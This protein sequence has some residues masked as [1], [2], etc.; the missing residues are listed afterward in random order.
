[1]IRL[2]FDIRGLGPLSLQIKTRTTMNGD[3]KVVWN[4]ED[5]TEGYFFT[6]DRYTFEED[7]S[8]Q[9]II[10]GSMTITKGKTNYIALDDI[11]FSKKCVPQI[12]P[13]P[14]V[15][16]QI[17][18]P[19]PEKRCSYNEFACTNKSQ[20]IPKEQKCDFK[21]DCADG[22]DETQC[23]K[24]DFHEDMCGLVNTAT[25]SVYQWKRVNA[26]VFSISK[27]ST[28][29]VSDSL[30][31][32][33]GYFA[34]LTGKQYYQYNTDAV[35]RTPALGATS[36][37][38]RLEFY[39][40]Y[41]IK[42]G[43]HL[44]VYVK[45]PGWY[46]STL[47]FERKD[48]D[49]TGKE[50][51]FESV[52]IGNY[53]AG[54]MIEFHGNAINPK[55][56][57]QVQDI[58]IDNINYVNCDPSQVYSDSL[59]CTFDNN[60]C[61]WH[62]DNDITAVTWTR[63]KKSPR[64]Y[65]PQSDHTGRKGFFMYISASWMYRKGQKA[66]LVSLKQNATDKRCFNFW[67]H[68]YGEDVGTLNLIVR[69]DTG[70]TT[71]WS[72]TNSQ[73]NA[74]KQ[75]MRT[76]RSE[77]P[78]QIV[79][80]GIV[81]SYANPVI[82][83]DDIEV[84]EEECPHPVACDFEA[85]F[86]E[87]N[88][89][90]FILQ[91]GRFNVPS[92]DHTTDTETGRYAALTEETGTLTSPDYNY[93]SN[94]YCLN[95]WYFLEGDRSTGLRVQRVE[96][97]KPDNATVLWADYA[98]P[99]IKGQWI[100]S[101]VSVT[102]LSSGDYNIVIF[103]QKNNLSNAVAVDDIAI[104][105]GACP[106][107]GSCNFERDF[108]TW[109]NLPKP[110]STG[111]QWLRNSGSI[112]NTNTGPK[113]D[114]TTGTTEGWYIY[115]D[116]SY[117]YTGQTAVLESENLHYSPNAC[118]KYWYHQYG[119]G[120]GSL[121]VKYVNHSDNKVYDIMPIRGSQGNNWYPVKRLVTGLPP[122][123]KIRFIGVKGTGGDLALDDIFI[124][125][126]TCD[127]PTTTI[128]PP[129]EFPPSEWDCDFEVGEFCKWING[130]GWT[131][132]D[133]R[134]ALVNKK[135]PSSDHT[136]GNALG[137]YAYYDPVNGTDDLISPTISTENSD[138]CF[139]FWYY[140]HSIAPISLEIH[141]LQYGQPAG[142]L[143]MK[144]A[145]A[146]TKW[147][148]GTYFFEKSI[149]MS[150]IFKPS[151]S[152]LGIG[153][154]AVDDLAFNEG[155]CP[156]LKG[157]PCDF[158]A[159]DICGF[160]LE[161]PDGIAWKRTQGKSIKGKVVGPKIDKSYGTSEGHY[162][163]VRPTTGSRT[164]GDN[165]AYIVMPN[166]P[167]TGVYRSC[168]RFWYQM[169]GENVV[170]LNLYMRTPGGSLPPFSLWSHSTKH[171]DN[172]WRVGQRTI[173]APYTHEILFEAVL[174]RGDKGF[175]AL[176]NVVVKEGG[177][178]N[179]GSCDFESDM[180]TWQNAE[181]GV[182]IEWVLNSGPT[183]TDNTGPDVDH[184][185]GTELGSYVYLQAENPAGKHNLVG[186][187]QSE[188]FS[189]ST[190]RCLSFWAHMSGKEMGSLQ[191][192]MSYYDE[193]KVKTL[194][195]IAWKI[196]GDKGN[197]W[198]NR[199]ININI[200]GVEIQEE[201]QI[202]LIGM[203]KGALSDIALDDIEVTNKKCY[204]VP[205]DAFDCRDGSHVNASKVCDFELDCPSGEDE[206]DCGECD[207]E[208]D[209]CGWRE[210]SYLDSQKWTRV[211]G[212]E[213]GKIKGPGYDHTFNTSKGHFMLV[214]APGYYSWQESTLQSPEKKLKKSYASCIMNFYF[215]HMKGS[216]AYIRV[217]KRIGTSTLATVWERSGTLAEGWQLGSAYLGTT[218][219]PFLIEFVHQSSY[220]LKYVAI[221][222]ITFQN[223]SMPLPKDKCSSKEFE[224]ANGRCV[225]RYFI[226]D[227]TD[228]CG[229]RS[230]EDAKLCA[231]YPKPCTFE[232]NGDCEWTVKGKARNYW[233]IQYASSSRN[234]GS[235]TGPLVDHTKGI[236]SV[237][238]YLM[239]KR[240][241]NDYKYY[242]SYY[243]SPNYQVSNE[244]YCSLRFYYYMHG[245]EDANLKVYTETEKDGWNWKERFSEAGSLGQKWNRGIVNVRSSKPYHYIIEGN[246]GNIT[247]S[248]IAIDDISL[249]KGCKLYTEDLPTPLPTPLP[250]KSPCKDNEF[251]CITGQPL[252]IPKSK[253]CDFTIDC[254]DKS[255][256][257]KCGPCSFEEDFC[258]WQNESPGTYEWKRKV[259]SED[260]GYGPKTDHLNST[261]GSFAY[262]AEGFGFYDDPSLLAS[263][264]LPAT[265]SHC[266]MAFWLN[267][268]PSNAGAFYVEHKSTNSYR[269]NYRKLWTMPKKFKKGW[270]LIEIKVPETSYKGSIVRFSNQ[271]NW[272]FW[273]KEKKI[274]AIDEISFISCNPK[275]LLVDCDFD[276]D[277]FNNGFCFWK[278]STNWAKWKRTKG[279][280]EKNFTGP[281]SDHTTG[282][283]YYLYSENSNGVYS[284]TAQIESPNLPMNYPEGS[285]FSFWY[286]MYGQHIGTLSIDTSY[287]WLWNNQFIR[288][289]NQGNQWRFGEF[290]IVSSSD[291]VI[292]VSAL[293]EQRTQNT[294]AVDDFKMIDGPCPRTA[295]C[296]F[297]QNLCGWNATFEG[298]AGWNRT[299]G[300]GNWSKEKPNVDHTTNSEFGH[301][302]YM[303]YK[304]RGDLSR[305]ESPL[306][307]NYGD[308]CVKFWYNMFGNDIG[309]LAVYQRTTQEGRIDNLKSL[310]KRSG[311]HAGGWKLGRVTMKSLPSFYIAFEA[312]TG[313]GP[314]GYIALDDI[315]VIHGACSD[316]GSCTFE[317]DTCGWTN[318]DAFAD[319]DWIRRTGL[320]V[321][322]GKG[323]ALDHSTASSQGHYMYALL[324]GL[325]AESRSMLASEDLEIFPDYCLSLW[326]NMFNTV[327]S[328]LL[329][330]QSIIGG[331][332]VD[333][334]EIKSSDVISDN[335][336]KLETNIT[337][338]DA[339]D[340]FQIGLTAF[341]STSQDNNT[342][343]GIA[344]DD[345]SLIKS[346]CG[347][348]IPTTV[349]PPTTTTEYPPSKFD[350]TFEVDLCLWENDEDQQNSAK[351]LIV[352]GHSEKK[353]TRPRTDHTTLS[354]SG[355]YITMNEESKRYYFDRARLLTQDGFNPNSGVC[356]KFWYHIYGN[357]PGSLYVKVRDFHDENKPT[358][359]MWFKSTSQGPNWQYEQVY[360]IKD[361]FFK[362]MVEGDGS[363]YGDISLDDFSLNEGDC[364]PRD[365]CDVEHDYCGFTHDPESDFQWKRGNGSRTNGPDV[366][367]TYGTMQ[368][369]Y[370]YVDP[371][372]VTT[373]GKI[374]RLESSLYKPDKK[375]MQFWYYL[376][377][378]DVGT[379][380]VLLRKGDTKTSKWKEV[381][382]NTK[383]WHAS[384]VI[385]DQQLPID[386]SYIFLVTT[387]SAFSSGKIALDD[388]AVKTECPPFGSCNFE[389][390]MCL[391][392][393]D[394]GAD[395]DWMR[396][397][398]EITE[399]G[400]DTDV[401]F[402]NQFGTYLY[403]HIVNEWQATPKPARLMSPYFPS[404]QK[405][406]FNYWNFRN[407]TSFDGALTVSMYND[408]T[409]EITELQHFTQEK[410]GRWSNEQFEIDQDEGEG[411]YQIIFEAQLTTTKNTFIALDDITVYERECK[412]IEDRKPDFT[413]E[414]GENHVSD[415]FRCDFYNDCKDG[416]D[417][418]D[419]GTS[420][421]F[422]A[423]EPQPCNWKSWSKNSQATWN[424]TLANYTEIPDTDHTKG[425]SGE[426]YYMK[427]NILQRWLYD[428]EAHFISP[429][430][431]QSSASCRMFF[432]YYFYGLRDTEALYAYFDSGHQTPTTEIFRLEGDHEKSWRRAEVI[433]GRVQNRFRVGIVGKRESATGVIA[434]D[435]LE[436]ENCYIP[437]TTKP[438]ECKEDQYLC[439]NGNCIPKDLMCDFVDDCGDYSDENRLLASCDLYPGRCDF[440]G[441]NYCG[442]Q[443]APE[444]DY[445][446]QIAKPDPTAWYNKILVTR[447]HTRNSVNG[448]FLYFGN[449]YIRGAVARMTSKVMEAVDNSCTFRFFY[450]YGTI[451]NSTK[452]DEMKDIG[453]LTV[454][455]RRDE[456]NVWKVIFTTR[457]P[458]GQYYEKVILP[459]GDLQEPFEI[460]VETR[461][462]REKPL[463]G[464]AVDDVS[465]TSGCVVSNKSLPLSIIDPTEEPE[466]SCNAGQFLCK[467]DKRCIDNEKVCDFV[468]DC[469]DSADEAKCGTCN[470]DDNSNPT[471]GW[472][473]SIG[474]RWVR[475]KG[476]TGSNGLTSDVSGNGYYMYVNKENTGIISSSSYLRSVDFKQAAATCEI[477]FYFFMSGITDEEVYLK[478]QLQTN[479]KK[480]VTLWEEVSD[481][482]QKW[483][484]A[485]V[486][487]NRRESGWHLDF[488]ASHAYSE[489]DIAIDEIKLLECAPPE[490]RKCISDR[491]FMCQSG[492]CINSSL[493]CDFS[494]DCPDR[495]DET[496][497]IDYLERCDFEKGWC[498]W[499][500]DTNADMLWKRTSGEQL[501]EGTGPDRDHTKNDETGHFLMVSR[502]NTYY[503]WKT[504]KL[505]ST[506]FMADVSSKCKLRFWYHLYSS[507][508]SRITVHVQE[509]DGIKS[510]E[511]D[512][513]YG[514]NG[515]EWQRAEVNLTNKFNFHAIIE[516]VP[517]SGRKG[518][519]AIDDTSFT[520]ECVPV[521]T[522][523][524]TPLPTI[525][526]KGI[527][528]RR[529]QFTCE[530]N[531]CVPMD[532]VCDFKTD[533]P[534]GIDEKSCPALC[535]FE[536]GSKC[537]WQPLTRKGDGVE[538]NVTIAEEGKKI[539]PDAPKVDKTTNTSQ[540]SYLI[541]HTSLET[542][543][544]P[545]DE[546]KS[547]MFSRCASPCKFSVWYVAKSKWFKPVIS[548][549]TGDEIT[550]MVNILPSDTW[551]LET[552]GIGRKNN[553]SISFNK[554]GGFYRSDF[555][556][557]DDIE[558]L[559]CALPK[560]SDDICLGFRCKTTRACID[561]SR[562]CDLTDDC[563]DATDEDSCADKKFITVDFENNT[564]GIFTQFK[565]DSAPLTWEIKKGMTAG[566]TSMRIG[567]P[568]DH[569]LSNKNGRYIS[570]SKGLYGGLEERAKL[571]S[572]VLYSVAKGE[573]EMRFYYFMFGQN[574]NQLNI[575]TT[576]KDKAAKKYKRIWRQT[577][578]VGN[579]WMRG[580]VVLDDTV[581]FQVII[582]GKAGIN[583][584]VIAM[585]DISFSQGCKLLPDTTLPPKEV[586]VT[587]GT[588]S[589]VTITGSV[590]PPT[591]PTPCLPTEF[592]CI[593]DK[594]CIAGDKKCDF[595]KDCKDGSDE[596]DCVKDF[597]DFENKEL[598]GWEIFH[599]N[600]KQTRAKRAADDDDDEHDAVFKWMPIQANDTHTE[601]NWSYRP[602][603]D[604]TT[605]TTTGW[606]LLADGA[607]GRRGDITSLTSPLISLT[608]A[609]CAVD[610]WLYCG[611]FSC[612]LSV[613]AQEDGSGSQKVWDA[614]NNLYGK[615]YS[616]V[617][618]H[619]KA[620][621]SALKNFRVRFDA[622][623]PYS[624]NSAVCLDDIAF[625]DC[626]PPKALDPKIE[627]CD[628]HEYMC[629]N[630]RCIKDNLLCDFTDDCGD[631]SDERDFQ[632]QDYKARC[633][634][635]TDLCRIWILENHQYAKWIVRSGSASIYSNIPRDDHTTR[636]STGKFLNVQSGG[637]LVKNA[638]PKVRSPTIDGTSENCTVRFY[639][640]TMYA[641]N[642]VRVYKRQNYTYPKGY[643]FLKEFTTDV[644]GYWH[645][646]EHTIANINKKDYQIVLEAGLSNKHG[647]LNID[648]ISLTP[649]C[650]LAQ[651][652]EIP[653]KPTVPPTIDECYEQG[654]LTCKNGNC[655][656]HLQRCNF[657]DDC[658]DNTDE[659]DCGTSCDFENG[660]C[661]WYNPDMYRGKWIVASSQGYYWSKLN[662]DHTYGNSSGHYI[663][664][665]GMLQQGD[666]A[667]FHT[668]NYVASG[669]NCKMS[670]WYFRES[671]GGALLRVLAENNV[672][673]DKFEV[674]F[675]N[676]SDG[677]AIWSN[678]EA[679]FP[680]KSHFSVVIE[681]IFG[682]GYLSSMAIDD[683]E[684]KNCRP[685][686][687]PVECGLQE[688]MC[689]DKKKCIQE[690][691]RCDGKP[692]CN[693]GT[694]E[695]NCPRVH[696]DC[697]FDDDWPELCDW[698]TKELLQ[699]EW[700]RA[701][702][703]RSNETGPPSSRNA[704]GFFLYMDSS[705]AEE[706]ERA[707][708][709]T[710]VFKPN[711]GNCHLRF[712][713]YMHGSTTIGTLVV[714]SEGENG[715]SFPVFT[716]KGPQGQ[717]WNYAH[718]A[719]GNDQHF[720]VTFMGI[721]GGDDKTDIAIDDVTFTQGCEKGGQPPRPTGP[722]TLCLKDDFVCRTG[723]QCIPSNWR[724]DCAY[725]CQDGSDED[726]CDIKCTSTSPPKFLS[727]TPQI[728]STTTPKKATTA[729]KT[730][731]TGPTTTGISPPTTVASCPDKTWRCHDGS[732][733]VPLLMLCDGV[734]DCSDGSDEKEKCKDSNLC[735]EMKYFCMDRKKDPCLPREKI[736]NGKKECSDGSDESLCDRCPPNF[737]LNGGECSIINHVPVCKCKDSFAQN[738]CKAKIV[739]PEKQEKPK[740]PTKGAGV[741]WI[742]GVVIG[743]ILLI[744]IMF[745]IWYK[746]NTN[747]E[748]ARLP[749]A[750]DNP[751]Y[752]L[753][754]DTLTFGELNSHMPVRTEDGAGATAI[755]NPLYA[756]KSEI[757]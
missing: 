534:L 417:E 482:G 663:K 303:P 313:E 126:D 138:Y 213:D 17:T 353:L 667:Q 693:G 174:E 398:G 294:I 573:C 685:D 394:P 557:I 634:F 320:D 389:D 370:F 400:P 714:L 720:R 170:G 280:T 275:E 290:E 116:G 532:A 717:Q 333:Q 58:A 392:F 136:Q 298:L 21:E 15:Q 705:K 616:Q 583:N 246:P 551:K 363:R 518:E 456:I 635:D 117:G 266:V 615:G 78:Y 111:L 649:A 546:F 580:T 183:P 747:A 163:I 513:F 538:I 591:T 402:G 358:E 308:M 265:S 453:T 750:V 165:K 67:Y 227:Q 72:K 31:N 607:P 26:E 499:T 173:D 286:H 307:N 332:W 526:P 63:A 478:L 269:S 120:S 362:I 435:D 352:E 385:I 64:N 218:E 380:E 194:N 360:I 581:P 569:T 238:K 439:Q 155:R 1:M 342:H 737:C 315:H 223:C 503:V 222:D 744:A 610:F 466:E 145:S 274:V 193:D 460:I 646:A 520:P 487:I 142:P 249:S 481:Q 571:I 252:C 74:W 9:V 348:E 188:Y 346:V 556:A 457:E 468:P 602:R 369:N 19:I 312:H 184:T 620:S 421:D 141:A 60:E 664:P 259:A 686:E 140:M 314:I 267:V 149:N 48:T 125:Q 490:K 701:N 147:K 169:T 271:P 383:F 263:P 56:S 205:E 700:E 438:Q 47:R 622:Q 285:C 231:S 562:V 561:D 459:L 199:Q 732:A 119:W 529:G 257:R 429:L 675:R 310:W 192:N 697:H 311:D 25:W 338:P 103:G 432:W 131:V 382:D 575:Y 61:G 250:T 670:F 335:W 642:S 721:R 412:P 95:F 203:T 284:S 237:G 566:H 94:S 521:Y 11:S 522:V 388:I 41:N 699:F 197:K 611:K 34:V 723:K 207:F 694:D 541:I 463:G 89:K 437:R 154:I 51:K 371:K 261:T 195:D 597:C 216:Q 654:K 372:E 272:S 44:Q 115:M 713:Y 301:F 399:V 39:Y 613:Y 757:K 22:S 625:Q 144:K 582:E 97:I 384:E 677:K 401:T 746:R 533:C 612:E 104:E 340:F 517:S 176:D 33:Q 492:E 672:K 349:S 638:N 676:D 69:T 467:A 423:D 425:L 450:T 297:E 105:D 486:S 300:S 609:Q 604:H 653:G 555:L 428:A 586:T 658:G 129:T 671:T 690:W 414:D 707:G 684:F 80:E 225:S 507:Y 447:D 514:S 247:N 629:G 411:K 731:G 262:V 502:E 755:E 226:C 291:Y 386:Y 678:G 644:T 427:V 479:D 568:Y 390:D 10:E 445:M 579:F 200:D 687:P 164:V 426:G 405:R 366:D 81:G 167:S 446:W 122:T 404:A 726:N 673:K 8:F 55:V 443:R 630:G 393:N 118:L 669:P 594:K 391:W 387:G 497:C 703:S 577:G 440:E 600:K 287:Y 696:G 268:N 373:K 309:T 637:Y 595:R 127:E 288:S 168:V 396:G 626:A 564:F 639:F 741:E 377:G 77:D 722:P 13:L 359:T 378:I 182:D 544:G 574:V 75:A 636:K 379:L 344:I 695:Q 214:D 444:T 547:P 455:A 742:I 336:I 88:S 494:E 563:G 137:R 519:I 433:I 679:T 295:Y 229:D 52:Y 550:D 201:Y 230:D 279:T 424:R 28:V 403:A 16:P 189:L 477:S 178:P 472:R 376:Y 254:F 527:C 150:V 683:I 530:D 232:M 524:T 106:P 618:T 30:G 475:R 549:T 337:V 292:R 627:V 20:C 729:S 23:G 49:A 159:A 325:K 650:H 743:T 528:D 355:H 430:L 98:D 662:K 506:P 458:P 523:I 345:L 177:C 6:E 108:C 621:L 54:R 590:T 397:S 735:T 606:Y 504:P 375:C 92:I 53:P 46:S 367:H 552:F 608:H 431:I 632:C 567:P 14:T 473:N 406:C 454:Y 239:I 593:E 415:D 220:E 130:D 572:D 381:G 73:G 248:I 357:S 305:L 347:K 209:D 114:H 599:K 418:K 208:H 657:I 496:N 666:V 180:C 485:T 258:G 36:H 751:V 660:T 709:Q 321:N 501:A 434:I 535:D 43:G 339:G 256:E 471:C 107:A 45:H 135:G 489:G 42:G 132:Q 682:S 374:A 584:D 343:R 219:Q 198:F 633:N 66:H 718:H 215:N 57:G 83:I 680:S 559:N 181:S 70:N 692:D 745:V 319:V 5:A 166:V 12:T 157:Q 278:Q 542:E 241:Y 539:T 236:D 407:G 508:T 50:W 326:Y 112:V 289:R 102:D 734:E 350:C 498:T 651:D 341:T 244:A 558:F 204:E 715:Q 276:D 733:C 354:T 409:D 754:L 190:E 331:G 689:K 134:K 7:R 576:I 330:E 712:W 570:M 628:A 317:I 719:I 395:L 655:Y 228:D 469:S 233:Y 725:D 156:V 623:R 100:H 598:C 186:I 614:Y 76:I 483:Q 113:T 619:A 536:S 82:A 40:H 293:M 553:F 101:R 221:D 480:D 510:I 461:V 327:N 643:E 281:T 217:R 146:D 645:R 124:Q 235:N 35:M 32:K 416:S 740:I 545:V 436:F 368:G 158:E 656:T 234:Y 322:Q 29:P 365:F 540:G 708:V 548:V 356:F 588:G 38:C 143:W 565:D 62:P 543:T 191:V 702:Q 316:S 515:D 448:Q 86:C 318:A 59:N 302:I 641:E 99:R 736:C 422:E 596:A 71:I 752:G 109:R 84:Y 509:A 554:R 206:Y 464:W 123:Y 681:M 706:G 624:Y 640:N 152:K 587:G 96:Q 211:Q 495:S 79:I 85:D 224:C 592:F 688:Y 133:G 419:C 537:G 243:H 470:F 738:R 659:K 283:G 474:R 304:R 449:S 202:L 724:C 512:N 728:Q 739:V 91:L 110:Y 525:Q 511:A 299:Q 442:W 323:P 698:Q 631:Y 749:H 704:K 500:Q 710:P 668:Q 753:N 410:L 484:N 491:E 488:I 711:E 153:D 121:Q 451:Y 531:S 351:W 212:E 329:I 4:R 148:Y 90:G 647:S 185:L 187:L 674:R 462:G 578:E 306:Y 160:K 162:M 175:I 242:S 296:D 756:F 493:V 328:S 255:D 68:M 260:D 277:N 465:F 476:Q 605:N 560:R 171:S 441:S 151:R 585:D 270:K 334:T 361:Y 93:T 27:N 196:E 420:C 161:S 617:W 3:E 413:C 282:H 589:P 18:T 452:Y 139:R 601:I 87:W 516:G 665:S 408:I 210:D 364:P 240:Y 748:R 251:K 691:E 2:Y 603:V 253:V 264:P 716:K 245:A 273:S 730:R 324:T 652:R 661:G 505:I 727:T 172:T 37:S 179:P 648:D 24:C 65:G 128:P